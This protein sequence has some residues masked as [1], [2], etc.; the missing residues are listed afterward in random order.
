LKKH[1]YL[2]KENHLCL[3]QEYLTHSF[4]VRIDLV[5][6]GNSSCKHRF[7]DGVMPSLLQKGLL[8]WVEKTHVS[9]QWK[10]S[11]IEAAA[12]S[13]LF[14]CERCGS[15][16][17]EYFLLILHFKVEKGSVYCKYAYSETL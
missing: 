17:K 10:P 1:M 11:M 13:T 6:E 7:Q 5:F 9:L 12:S 15:F 3:K 8:S 4:P 2:S 14:P 16:W